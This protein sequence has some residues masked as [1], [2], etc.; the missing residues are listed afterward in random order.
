MYNLLDTFQNVCVCVRACV[1][2]DFW[3]PKEGCSWRF[4]QILLDFD[5]ERLVVI[6]WCLVGSPNMSSR[7]NDV[8]LHSFTFVFTQT[9]HISNVFTLI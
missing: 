7:E 5:T 1:F 4:L 2:D 3:E 9:Q 8:G 6:P